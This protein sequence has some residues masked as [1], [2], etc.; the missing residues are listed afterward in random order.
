M[1]LSF[2][3]VASLVAICFFTHAAILQ[4]FAKT[5]MRPGRPLKRPVLTVLLC[6]FAAHLVEAVVYA[7]GI[8][9][10]VSAGL[11]SLA[12]EV[13]S[14]EGWVL[15]HF[16][17]SL[18]SYTSLGIG[19]IIPHGGLRLLAGVEALNGLVLI[20]WSASFTYLTMERFWGL[21]PPS[22]KAD[23]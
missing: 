20:A 3:I 8:S 21:G 5:L 12:G 2:L 1:A 4:R 23:G 6:I 15:D 18:A 14:K 10:I 17:F 9:L 16:Y 13:G 11:G 22:Q 19:D 7:I